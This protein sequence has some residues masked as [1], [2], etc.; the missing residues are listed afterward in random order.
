MSI[1]AV[2][3]SVQEFIPKLIT[4][5]SSIQKDADFQ[6]PSTNNTI[7]LR[8]SKDVAKARQN[9]KQSLYTIVDSYFTDI[10]NKDVKSI[11]DK[12]ITISISKDQF[13][14]LINRFYTEIRPL[15]ETFITEKKMSPT[16]SKYV[17]IVLSGLL[18]EMSNDAENKN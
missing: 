3:K 13:E 5:F 8:E 14:I 18:I 12:N 1:R 7:N 10:Q 2:L 17:T 15:C 16:I 6:D 4:R 11:R 9:V